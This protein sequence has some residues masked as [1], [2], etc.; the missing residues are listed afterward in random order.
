LTSTAETHF[1][2]ALGDAAGRTQSALEQLLAS[3]ASSRL[4]AAMRYSALGAGKRLRPFLV[5][6]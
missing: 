3:S 4:L 2:T 6:E 5:I 1:E